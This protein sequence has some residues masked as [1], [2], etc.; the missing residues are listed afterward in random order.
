MS[1]AEKIQS[2][3]VAAMKARNEFRLSVLRMV[4]AAIQLKE[5]EKVRKLDEAESIQLLQG[6]LKQR[7]ESIEQ[8]TKGNRPDLAEKETK[9]AAIIEEYLPAAASSEEMTA[10]IAKA[11]AETGATSIKQ[12][13]SVVKA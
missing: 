7:R 1:L 9:E 3:V 8:F 12:M 10:A 11:I 2:D 6:I 5:V 4:K 13:G